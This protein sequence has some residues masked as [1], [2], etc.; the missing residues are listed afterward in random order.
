MVFEG[1]QIEG[2]VYMRDKF[3]RGNRFEGPALVCE[4]S[5]TTVVPP[6][7]E[8]RVDEWGNLVLKNSG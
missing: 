7:W 5:A 6:G 2:S 4:F 3:S 1:K 8:C